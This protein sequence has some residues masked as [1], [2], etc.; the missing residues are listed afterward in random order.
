MISGRLRRSLWVLVPVSL[1]TLAWVGM[2]SPV[3]EPDPCTAELLAAAA[4]GWWQPAGVRREIPEADWPGEL[5]WLGSEAVTV[6]PEGMYIRFRSSY[7]GERALIILPKRSPLRPR[8]D[9]DPS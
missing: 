2:L 4:A 7:V 8:Q 1:A 6:A 5:R 3:P 9:T